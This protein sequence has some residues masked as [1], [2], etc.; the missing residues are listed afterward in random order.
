[1][2]QL[3]VIPSQTAAVTTKALVDL[4]AYESGSLTASALA[5]TEEVDIW[6]WSGEAWV[7]LND[8]DGTTI[9]LTASRRGVTLQGGMVYAVAKD[10]TASA[11][12]VSVNL[13]ASING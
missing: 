11:C 13:G 5:T 6:Y 12:S 1:M 9:S 8:A 2:A 4:S 7:L 10:A 3:L